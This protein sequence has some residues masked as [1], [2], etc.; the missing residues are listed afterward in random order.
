MLNCNFPH[1]IWKLTYWFGNPMS[2][3]LVGDKTGSVTSKISI[4]NQHVELQLPQDLHTLIPEMEIE[5]DQI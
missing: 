5:Q 4:L 2:E 1:W 3:G